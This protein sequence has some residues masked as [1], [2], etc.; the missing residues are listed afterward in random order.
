[1]PPPRGWGL[2]GRPKGMT[3]SCAPV[4]W[5]EGRCDEVLDY[6]AQDVKTTLDLAT[7]CE[8]C[9]ELRWVARSGRLRCMALG[10]G[11]LTVG[12]ALGLPIP[13]TSWMDDPWKRSDFTGW[14]R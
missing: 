4:L 6:V 13:D 5:A 7:A 11:W 8:T 1:M 2:P 3:A 14:I 9:G 12:E 10:E